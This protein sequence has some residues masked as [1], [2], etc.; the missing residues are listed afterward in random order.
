MIAS[1]R[2]MR[3]MVDIRKLWTASRPWVIAFFACA[4]APS[5]CKAQ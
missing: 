2:P 1:A 3:S 5:P 4:I